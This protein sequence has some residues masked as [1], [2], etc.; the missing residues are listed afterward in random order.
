MTNSSRVYK[1][2]DNRAL[3]VDLY[4]PQSGASPDAAIT[5]LHGGGWV[6]GHRNTLAGLAQA[7]A[8]Q[9]Y[10]V[11]CPEYRLLHEAAWPAQIEDAVAAARWAA[12]NAVK[13]GVASGRIVLAGCSAGGHLALLA[14]AGLAGDP[15]LSAVV[16]LF[17]ASEL[18]ISPRPAKG[19]FNATALLG[20]DAS[21]EA[22]A[23]AAP[24]K[25][26]T[27]NFPPAL[28]LHGGADWFI[29]PVASIHLFERFNELGVPAEL[30]IFGKANH[31]FSSEPSMMG[32][33]AENFTG[34]CCGWL[35]NRE[36]MWPRGRRVIRCS[37]VAVRHSRRLLPR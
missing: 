29:D 2:V 18:A 27:A 33:V 32:V 16:S 14:T 6:A 24:L 5:L 9:G 31:E 19:E 25:Q 20:A 34:S 10:V 28:L 3:Q 4:H 37:D 36:N 23:A 11:L 30:H 35:S 7:I 13:L 15:R 26:L 12:D 22:L 1:T 8:D 17:S 21:A